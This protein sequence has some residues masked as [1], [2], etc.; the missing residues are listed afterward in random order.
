LADA[1]FPYLYESSATMLQTALGNIYLIN[2]NACYK[3]MKVMLNIKM[4]LQRMK[5]AALNKE[6]ADKFT[7]ISIGTT[8]DNK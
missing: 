2:A 8:E 5:G 1:I 6:F 7:E 4:L 3:V